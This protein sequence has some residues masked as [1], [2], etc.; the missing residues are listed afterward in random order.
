MNVRE[1]FD[2][3]IKFEISNP[4]QKCDRLDDVNTFC[5]SRGAD[6]FAFVIQNVYPDALGLQGSGLGYEGIFGALA[7][8]FDTYHNFDQMDYYEN[9][10]SVL[11][12]V[13]ELLKICTRIGE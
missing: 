4:S 10:I 13:S 11:T 2:T 7:V 8:E 3:F 5:R 6:G 1:G 9:H 12:Q